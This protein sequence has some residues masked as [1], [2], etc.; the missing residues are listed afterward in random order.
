MSLVMIITGFGG[1]DLIAAPPLIP[2]FRVWID[3]AVLL[4][5]GWR[6]LGLATDGQSPQLPFAPPLIAGGALSLYYQVMCNYLQSQGWYP[7][8]VDIDWR[9]TQATNAQKVA[10]YL[11]FFGDQGD[12]KIICHSRGG[13]VLRRALKLL[14][15]HGS[16]QSISR[17]VGLGVPHQGAVE[18]AK[19]L[20]GTS[21]TKLLLYR[22]LELGPA[23]IAGG[24]PR[25]ALNQIIGTWPAGYELLPSPSSTWLPIDQALACY[26]ASRWDRGGF[27]IS[28]AWLAA[29]ETAWSALAPSP[30]AIDWIDVVGYGVETATSFGSVSAV[31]FT[32]RVTISTDGDGIVTEGSA[33]Q[34]GRRVLRTPTAHGQMP[35][36]G[37]LLAAV[38]NVLRSGLISDVTLEG[39]VLV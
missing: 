2:R 6:L 25:G 8:P 35:F 12:V 3:Y 11:D 34:L 18:A 30:P 22:L 10:D 4:A 7:Y 15:G 5:Q 36:D 27:P 13:L 39:Q 19:L 16:L 26:D 23:L 32:N 20:N 28:S 21:S 1:N 14:E 38:D 37:R 29:G 17:I 9:M 33:R 31:P 24:Y